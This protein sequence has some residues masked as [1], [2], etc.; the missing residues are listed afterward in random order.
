MLNLKRRINNST[1]HWNISF[2]VR[3]RREGAS[4]QRNNTKTKTFPVLSLQ[5]LYGVKISEKIQKSALAWTC[6]NIT[7]SFLKTLPSACSLKLFW[8]GFTVTCTASAL[9]A[10]STRSA[11]ST[12]RVP[13]VPKRWTLNKCTD[14]VDLHI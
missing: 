10:S 12:P 8:V 7:G 1:V 6:L 9:S 3:L 13:R 11:T 5:K 4:A 14:F 2:L